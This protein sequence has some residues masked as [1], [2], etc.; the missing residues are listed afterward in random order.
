M[1]HNPTSKLVV[2]PLSRSL[3]ATSK[4]DVSFFSYGYLDVSVHRV[5]F[6]LPMYS[7]MDTYALPYVGSPIRKSAGQ[8]ICAPYRSFSQ[9]ITS[10][11]GSQCQGI[12]LVLLLLDHNTN[13]S[14]Q[15]WIFLSFTIV[16]RCELLSG[17]SQ[18]IF[19]EIVTLHYF[20]RSCLKSRF[21]VYLFSWYL[22]VLFNFQGT[23]RFDISSSTS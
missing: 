11:F 8:W 23:P 6:S 18:Q 21:V 12:H 9:L 19:S 16:S 4:I 20:F 2:W 14:V 10:F 1:V 5:P 3:A 7:V 22:I 17:F 15:Y 13:I